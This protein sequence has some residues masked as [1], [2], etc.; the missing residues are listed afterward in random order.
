MLY[1]ILLGILGAI[2]GSF[3]ATLVLRWPAGRTVGGRSACDGCG[4]PLGAAE[5][6]PLV[7]AALLRGRCRTCRT[8]I[9]PLHWQV[10]AAAAAIGALSG[11]LAPSAAGI[12][13]A[14]FGWLL[15]TLA[16][17]DLRAWWLPD[18][19]T[20][21]LAV[22][23]VASGLAGLG[24]PLPDRVIGG[25]AGFALLWLVG[26]GYRRTRGREGMGGGDPKLFG[27]I[28][29]WLGWTMLPPVLLV[30][31]LCGLG[32]V[33]AARLTGRPM[34]R[35]DALPLGALLAAAAWPAWALMADAGMIGIAP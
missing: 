15:L 25:V 28:G 6:V 22:T 18:I 1:P 31:S 16:L 14:V 27:G 30:A 35:T 23:G 33:L 13:G 12:A 17:L 3:I 24:P 4:R 2:L 29:L 10:E 8:A 32:V 5:L 19:L 34:I 7:S 9:A 26:W 21:S 20:G 11:W